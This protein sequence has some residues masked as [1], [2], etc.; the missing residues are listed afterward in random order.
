[1]GKW[2]SSKV[3]KKIFVQLEKFQKN[4]FLDDLKFGGHVYEALKRRWVNFQIILLAFIGQDV[5]KKFFWKKRVP[6]FFSR[7]FKKP[8]YNNFYLN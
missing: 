7:K 1:L 4:I 3:K 2:F 5:K 8:N 6:N